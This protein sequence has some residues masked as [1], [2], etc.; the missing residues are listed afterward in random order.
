MIE[1]DLDLPSGTLDVSNTTTE[2]LDL[3]EVTPGPQRIR[4][5]LRTEFTDEPMVR[6][7]L[8]E[9]KPDA[10]KGTVV[11]KRHLME[12]LPHEEESIAAFITD[13]LQGL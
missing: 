1:C 8:W 9:A 5:H 11:L 13:D 4:I 10:P 2:I 6:V 7:A 12:D 3:V